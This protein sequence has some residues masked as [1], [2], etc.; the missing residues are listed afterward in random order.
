MMDALQNNSRSIMDRSLKTALLVDGFWDRW[1]V[2]GLEEEDLLL[3]RSS[4]TTVEKWVELWSDLAAEKAR[5]AK[6]LLET[7]EEQQAEA[8]FRKAS[9]YYNLTQWI[10]PD[11]SEEKRK[12]Y[13][14]CQITIREADY[15]SSVETHYPKISVEGHSCYGRVRTPTHP[16]GC[17]IIINPIDS[18]KE[19]LYSYELDFLHGGFAVVSFDGPG[20]GETFVQDEFRG[21]CGRW[22]T[23]INRAIEYTK[24]IFSHLPIYL[25]GTSFGASWVLYG[26]CRP[27]VNGSVAVS[28]AIR[29]DQMYLPGYFNG[30]MDAVLDEFDPIPNLDN[31]SFGRRILLYHGEKDLLVP[32]SKIYD[33]VEKFPEG[34]KFTEYQDEGHCCNYKLDQIRQES[35]QWFMEINNE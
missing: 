33:L 25:F 11:P 8:L 18:T 1:L 23:L 16:K 17:V 3:I 7:G 22:E 13:E 26:S 34:K 30:R 32:S 9:L 27:E 4:L 19:E 31:L 35:L 2:H 28:P 12:W 24:S 6:E 10:F 20:Q 14:L 21:T 15:L 29:R 5:R